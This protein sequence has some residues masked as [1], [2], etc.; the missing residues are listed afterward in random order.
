M[1]IYLSIYLSVYVPI[2][3]YLSIYKKNIYIY[4]YIYICLPLLGEDVG[5]RGHVRGPRLA[6]AAVKLIVI[7]IAIT[8]YDI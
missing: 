5:L 7:V 3:L 1:S 2:Y 6:Q 8:I 4:I